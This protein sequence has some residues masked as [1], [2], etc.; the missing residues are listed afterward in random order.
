MDG[1]S[2]TGI[3]YHFVECYNM[4]IIKLTVSSQNKN[5]TEGQI[6]QKNVT[7]ATP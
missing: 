3:E 5:L 7:A 1:K 4:F 2:N 6:R